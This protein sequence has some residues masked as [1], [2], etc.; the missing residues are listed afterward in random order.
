MASSG[1]ETRALR[2]T[3]AR[4]IEH[5]APKWGGTTASRALGGRRRDRSRDLLFVRQFPLVRAWKRND[6]GPVRAR[7]FLS[8][9][10]RACLVSWCVAACQSSPA[11]TQ[12]QSAAS[13]ASPGG[14]AAVA[15]VPVQVVVVT[16]KPLEVKVSATGTLLA[17]ESVEVVAELSRRL[18]R[19]VAKEGEY[20][21]KG[22]LLYELDASDLRAELAVLE[23]DT[24][25]A[26]REVE[27]QTALL[28]EQITTAAEQEA[29]QSRLAAL[30]ARR[31]TVLVT[32]AKTQVRAPFAGTLGLRRVSEG[33]WVSPNT[34][35]TTLEDLSRL[36]VD[37]TLPERYAPEV[38]VGRKFSVQVA[39]VA[40]AIEGQV[41][42][43]EST[44]TAASRSL[45]IRGE[46]T[47]AKGVRPGN[48][49]KISLTLSLRDAL[50][51]PAIAVTSSA[52]GRSVFIVDA[53]GVARVTKVDVGH[54][55][56]NVVEITAGLDPGARVVTT[57]LL[58][59]RDG[60]PVQVTAEG[61]S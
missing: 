18:V 47:D 42:A 15:T 22:A 51:V 48:F 9:W 44:V 30:A 29:A 20:V 55:D 38:E 60:L 12:S 57:N 11:A 36:K 32:L 40:E 4:A 28:K 49:A 31:N 23:V 61:G 17:R 37:F 8:S 6:T 13:G 5:R 19:V 25:Q 41:V 35:I 39:G 3:Q 59:L 52:E 46:L 14:S 53:Q 54:R 16:P 43:I 21:K 10:G 27:R 56:A 7:S 33:A 34:V 1:L 24:E 58:R 50:V 45:V 26:R 2:N